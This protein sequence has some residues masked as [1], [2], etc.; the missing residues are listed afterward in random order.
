MP[1]HKDTAYVVLKIMIYYFKM[2]ELLSSDQY[3]KF[4]S[5]P[6]CSHNYYYI[7]ILWSIVDG[8]TRLFFFLW[9]IWTIV[10]Q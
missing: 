1:Y 5:T 10:I 3:S 2:A 8:D 6:N 4:E 9:I 7:I